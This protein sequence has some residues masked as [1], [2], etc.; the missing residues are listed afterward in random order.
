MKSVYGY[1]KQTNFENTE[2]EAECTYS[3]ANVVCSKGLNHLL[4]FGHRHC[5]NKI[6]KLLPIKRNIATILHMRIW[7]G[8]RLLY[9]HIVV[10]QMYENQILVLKYNE[11]I[12]YCVTISLLIYINFK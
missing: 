11:L 10:S 3:Y 6:I 7:I 4:N 12:T 2:Y 1:S 5:L 8:L 9:F